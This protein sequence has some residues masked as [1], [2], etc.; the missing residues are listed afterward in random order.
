[1]EYLTVVLTTKPQ[2]GKTFIQFMNTEDEATPESH[3]N[4]H[5]YSSV[6]FPSVY[7]KL[8]V[9]MSMHGTETV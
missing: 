8:D 7:H 5:T 3:T 2:T 6:S 9:H 4:I 1:M